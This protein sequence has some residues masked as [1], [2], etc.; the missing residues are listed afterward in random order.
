MPTPVCRLDGILGP[1]QLANYSDANAV[2]FRRIEVTDGDDILPQDITID[3]SAVEDPYAT[4][5]Y[6]SVSG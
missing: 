6:C 1:F 5:L 2:Q 4:L 3:M